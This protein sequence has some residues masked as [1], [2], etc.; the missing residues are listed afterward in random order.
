MFSKDSFTEKL[1]FSITYSPL[2]P[3]IL[4]KDLEIYFSTASN[5]SVKSY[6][7]ANLHLIT[8]KYQKNPKD[9]YI[10]CPIIGNIILVK[11]QQE[12]SVFCSFYNICRLCNFGSTSYDLNHKYV[13]SSLRY[14]C[15]H[16]SSPSEFVF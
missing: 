2:T 9:V 6:L 5:D 16:D 8:C 15:F 14:L 7:V 13:V 4:L 11:H 1:F 3:F 12:Y 10:K